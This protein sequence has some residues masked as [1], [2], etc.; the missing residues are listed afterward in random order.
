MTAVGEMCSP[1]FGP[2]KSALLNK[3][4]RAD[5]HSCTNM[6]DVIDLIDDKIKRSEGRTGVRRDM[7]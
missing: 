4:E 1:G 2:N 7:V 3:T 5:L 6:F